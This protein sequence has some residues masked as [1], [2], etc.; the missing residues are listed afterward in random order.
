MQ[1]P[2][3]SYTVVSCSLNDTP[4]ETF[5]YILKIT[6]IYTAGLLCGICIYIDVALHLKWLEWLE[7]S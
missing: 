5:V 7:Q 6:Q 1:Q 2:G 4:N 3:L